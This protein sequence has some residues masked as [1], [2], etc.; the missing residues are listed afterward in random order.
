MEE[1]SELAT[2][3]R[4]RESIDFTKTFNSGRTVYG[5]TTPRAS[6]VKPVFKV[7][8]IVSNNKVIVNAAPPFARSSV[9]SQAKKTTAVRETPV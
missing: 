1:I 7:S 3:E 6:L 5:N 9:S 2:P 4:V 8:E